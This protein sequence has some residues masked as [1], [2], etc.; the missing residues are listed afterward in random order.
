MK[1]IILLLFL[2]SASAQ[3]G[4]LWPSNSTTTH[5]LFPNLELGGSGGA[6]SQVTGL[7]GTTSTVSGSTLATL[8]IG[9][10]T[11]VYLNSDGSHPNEI[12][13]SNL[14]NTL[15]HNTAIVFTGAGVPAGLT[16]GHTYYSSGGFVGT[17]L[18]PD[19]IRVLNAPNGSVVPLTST[20]SGTVL[21]S[22]PP[23]IV[24]NP[25]TFGANIDLGG[26]YDIVNPLT[27]SAGVGSG[28]ASGAIAYWNGTGNQLS[29]G[30]MIVGNGFTSTAGPIDIV[31]QTVNSPGNAGQ[32]SSICGGNGQDANGTG[33]GGACLYVDGGGQ[34]ANSN[35][36]GDATLSGGLS[37][38]N[39]GSGG[40]GGKL[41]LMGNDGMTASGVVSHGSKIVLSPGPGN[42][43]S[44]GNIQY[45]AGDAPAGSTNTPG[46]IQ[47]F[48]AGQSTGNQS[49]GF[50]FQSAPAGASGTSY[51]PT[52]L[53]ATLF[54]GSL[55]LSDVTGTRTFTLSIP[56]LASSYTLQLPNA[57]S[58]GTGYVPSFNSTG[59]GSW[60]N[61]TAYSPATLA[62]WAGTPPATIKDAL[63]RLAAAVSNNGAVPIP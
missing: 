24:V 30:S 45:I 52:V 7:T 61:P 42:G 19:S 17:G 1:K 48:N 63:D 25:I 4:L 15:P 21:V 27:P 40:S 2:A 54:P 60:L 32:R 33:T 3:A 49:T 53:T 6:I 57:Q 35:S 41:T 16:P 23:S 38:Y 58:P 26:T 50:Q 47:I 22:S 51:N 46:G 20:G 14:G 8:N 36:G 44:G 13:Q 37:F 39:A 59:I 10:D 55:G 9:S 11:T 29:G 12:Q 28:V 43:S 56:A 34:D 31:G 18:G 5:M 62:N